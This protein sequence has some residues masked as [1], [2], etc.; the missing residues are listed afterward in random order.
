[1]KYTAVALITDN[2]ASKMRPTVLKQNI[3]R[4]HIMKFTAS[5][6]TASDTVSQATPIGLS[7]LLLMTN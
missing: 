2:T 6:I 1:M 3:V 4:Q 5:M 7:L